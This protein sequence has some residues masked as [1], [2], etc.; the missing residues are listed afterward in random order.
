MKGHDIEVWQGKNLTDSKTTQEYFDEFSSNKFGKIMKTAVPKTL[1]CMKYAHYLPEYHRLFSDFGAQ[2]VNMLEIGVQHGGSY[3]LWK[4]YFGEDLLRWTGI[5][6]NQKCLALNNDLSAEKGLVCC[7]SQADPEFLEDVASRR[8]EFDVVIDDGSHQ[9][10]HIVSSFKSL[11]KHV[12]DG[13]LYIIEDIHAC[14][15]NGFR[16]VED[17]SNAL[18][19]FLGLAHSLNVQAIRHKRCSKNLSSD[20]LTTAP[21]WIRKIELLPSMVICH[22]GAPLPMIEWKAG[23]NSVIS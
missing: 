6:I 22:M 15:W 14:Y 12:K 11:A 1:N 10:E 8:G 23:R 21:A 3:R 4:N 18:S 5:D 19:Y 7:G 20:E 13:G 16:G 2:K 9:S 17:S